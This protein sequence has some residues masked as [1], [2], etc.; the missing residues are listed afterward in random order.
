M[1]VGSLSS[2]IPARRRFSN[3]AAIRG[4]SEGTPVSFSTSEARMTACSGV[5]NG[6]PGERPAQSS[7]SSLSRAVRIFCTTSARSSPRWT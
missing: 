4:R 6:R 1:I 2:L 5:C 3:T 7:A